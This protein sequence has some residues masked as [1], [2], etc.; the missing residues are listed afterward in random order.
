MNCMSVKHICGLL[1]FLKGKPKTD[2][3]F[4]V[5]NPL[6]EVKRAEMPAFNQ[7]L[8]LSLL[9]R[10]SQIAAVLYAQFL[11][12]HQH[13]IPIWKTIQSLFSENHFLLD[14][15]AVCKIRALESNL[16][17]LIST[18]RGDFFIVDNQEEEKEGHTSC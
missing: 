14:F 6:T 10:I 8:F 12:A 2:C 3:F 17:N 16:S 18:D 13:L 7:K 1:D 15:T 9:Q 11:M 4:C 5:S